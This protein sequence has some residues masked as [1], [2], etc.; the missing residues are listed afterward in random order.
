MNLA[1]F[2]RKLIDPTGAKVA[3]MISGDTHHY[4]R[5]AEKGTDD[6]HLITCGNG[7]AYLAATHGLPATVTVP[8]RQPFAR[9]ARRA[10]YTLRKTYPSK[11][12]SRAL[13]GGIFPKLPWRN[14]GFATLLGICSSLLLL[15]LNS[16][17][18]SG[19][20]CRPSS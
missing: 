20:A 7:G 4:A 18:T 1:Y 11:G 14:P 10:G 3:V 8:P 6:E 9:D 2:R 16:R 13:G 17:R 19:S 12:R 5:Y 15:S